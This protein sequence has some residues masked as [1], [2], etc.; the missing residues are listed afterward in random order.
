MKIVGH[1]GAARQYPENTKYGFE[2]A[3]EDGVRCFEL[4]LHASKD[5]TP[6]IIHDDTTTR[7]TGKKQYVRQSKYD[8]LMRL[9]IPT[10]NQML[11]LFE[12]CDHIQL[13]IK[14]T[15]RPIF[16]FLRYQFLFNIDPSNF[17]ITSDNTATLDL[18]SIMLPDAKLGIVFDNTSDPRDCVQIAMKHKCH[19]IV[20]PDMTSGRDIA[21]AKEYGLTTS[22]YTINDS[23]KKVW[24]EERG[25][26]YLITDV[27]SSL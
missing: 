9:G 20:F 13:E 24:C 6:M 15:P 2:Q 5:G 19:M 12:K 8:A 7:T 11:P 22:I 1:R 26:D 4:D 27:P 25:I 18:A 14:D 23:E 3:F 10:L 17:W 21:R 16:E